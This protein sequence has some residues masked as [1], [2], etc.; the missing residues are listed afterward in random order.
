MA[1]FLEEDPQAIIT[2][3]QKGSR[4]AA[5]CPLCSSAQV[6]MTVKV[7]IQREVIV[8]EGIVTLR[9]TLML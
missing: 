8:G 5:R 2:A 9:T 7:T 1:M 4:E 6:T 3:E